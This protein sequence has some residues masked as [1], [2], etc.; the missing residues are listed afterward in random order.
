SSLNSNEKDSSVSL[1]TK[2]TDAIFPSLIDCDKP[3]DT[4]INL[5]YDNQ[6]P[7]NTIDYF[8]LNN[9]NTIG[10]IARLTPV[11]IE[12]YPI[13]SPKLANIQQAL[14]LYEEQLTKSS[15]ISPPID[16]MNES[17]MPIAT[18]N[19]NIS[20]MELSSVPIAMITNQHD[21]LYDVDTLID[22]LDYEKLYLNDKISS[23][24]KF[25]RK[26]HQKSLID[27]QELISPQ[28]LYLTS[29]NK[30]NEHEQNNSRSLKTEIISNITLGDRLQKAADIYKTK[31][32]LPFDN[33]YIELIRQLFN[34]SSLTHLEQLHLKALFLNQ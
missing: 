28:K 26:R 30:N 19:E 2:V 32:I 13:P 21:K 6:C 29:I 3:I 12:I 10:D 23:P 31:G 15:S 22:S 33:D 27:Q 17:L 16:N 34:N 20:T 1:E 14:S 5:L 11:Q 24:T 8:H 18:N 7:T 4:F 9:I 25:L